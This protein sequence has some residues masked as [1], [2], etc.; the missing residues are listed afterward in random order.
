M[1]TIAIV[2]TMPSSAQMNSFSVGSIPNEMPNSDAS[3]SVMTPL[4]SINHWVTGKNAI[5]ERAAA[6]KS[7]L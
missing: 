2:T 3:A 4:S 7:P 1:K 5:T 6:P